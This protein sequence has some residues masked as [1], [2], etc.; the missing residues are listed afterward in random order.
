MD[1]A[2][3]IK[4]Q[5]KKFLKYVKSK[6]KAKVSVSDH[7]TEVGIIASADLEKNCCFQY[8]F[9]TIFTQ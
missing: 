8:I 2:R 6:A 1:L 3:D 9:S 4:V 7:K 5:A